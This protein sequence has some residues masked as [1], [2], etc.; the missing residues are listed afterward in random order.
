MNEAP[1]LLAYFIAN[2]PEK[3]PDWFQ[4]D[5]PPAPEPRYLVAGEEVTGVGNAR[6]LKKLHAFLG[7]LI[8]GEVQL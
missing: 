5:V 4:P 3:I 1:S 8:R 7:A 6:R 2:A